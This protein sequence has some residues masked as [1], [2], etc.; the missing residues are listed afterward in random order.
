MG[1]TI[2]IPRLHSALTPGTPYVAY[3]RATTVVGDAKGWGVASAPETA[4][5]DYP[6]KPE[7]PSCPWQWPT[8]LE[9][10]V[11]WDGHR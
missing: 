3:V 2:E 6:S 8:A 11:V 10:H 9:A 5:P 4:P 7:K 1:E